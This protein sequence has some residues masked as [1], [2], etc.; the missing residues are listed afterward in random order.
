MSSLEGR[1]IVM[2][3]GASGIGRAAALA[4]AQNGA[5]L[6]I[7]DI[8]EAGAA[9]TADLVRAAGVEAEA[10]RCDVSQPADLA[11]LIKRAEQ[12]LGGVDVVFG[13]AGVLQTAP[14]EELSLQVF[15]H[16]LAVN[17]TANF[18]LAKLTAETMRHRGGGSM[19]FTASVGGLRGSAGSAAYNASKGGL[20]NLVRSLADEL[21]PDGIRVNC[22]CPG[23]VDTPFNDPYWKHAGP[24]ALEEVVASIPLRRQSA[25]DEIAPTV[26]FLAGDG[27][28]Y[29]T[30]TA[31]VIDGGV[32]AK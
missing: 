4:F 21:G 19:I 30:G 26:V 16:S 27:A 2:T 14:L 31:I 3:G 20:V 24:G 12:R 25:P 5:N 11:K 10:V 8:D 6:I 28:R 17:L 22:I 32:F 29:I 18:V 15:E 7:G 1:A 23:W 9:E 13:N